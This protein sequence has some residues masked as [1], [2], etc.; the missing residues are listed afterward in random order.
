MLLS[1]KIPNNWQSFHCIDENK[2]QLFQLL[3]EVLLAINLDGKDLYSIFGENVLC[4]L[5]G[6][7]TH[8]IEP[9]ALEEADT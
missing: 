9:C 3:A 4:S 2:T 5:A 6:A 1:S 8:M 7:E